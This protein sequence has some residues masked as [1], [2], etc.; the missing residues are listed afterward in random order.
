[1]NKLGIFL[2]VIPFGM[3]ST[4]EARTCPTTLQGET[5]PSKLT[6]SGAL[7]AVSETVCHEW[8]AAY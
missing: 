1:M 6:V 8:Q 5:D 7:H 4:S 2:Y 3:L